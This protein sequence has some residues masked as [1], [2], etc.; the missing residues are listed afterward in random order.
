MKKKCSQCHGEGF[1]IKYPCE[2]DFFFLKS[3]CNGKGIKERESFE[4]FK[5]PKGIITGTNIRIEQQVPFIEY[6]RVMRPAFLMFRMGI[7]L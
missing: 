1:L 4:N 6:I 7:Y 5:L 3:G 2:Y